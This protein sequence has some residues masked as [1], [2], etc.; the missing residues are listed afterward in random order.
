MPHSIKHEDLA[1]E[2]SPLK[3]KAEEDMLSS[4][5]RLAVA[6]QKLEAP[7]TSL[8]NMKSFIQKLEQRI[9]NNFPPE[10]ESEELPEAYLFDFSLKWVSIIED[11]LYISESNKEVRLSN[12][13]EGGL[14]VQAELPASE[15]RNGYYCDMQNVKRIVCWEWNEKRSHVDGVTVY[16]H[17]GLIR[18]LNLAF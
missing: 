5:E 14:L 1:A 13:F 17:E 11:D 8:P 4:I 10:G 3:D 16:F 9:A 6:R 18:T 15:G 7:G 12:D 2:Y